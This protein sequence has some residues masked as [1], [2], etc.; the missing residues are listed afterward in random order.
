MADTTPSAS[1]PSAQNSVVART[2]IISSLVLTGLS[3]ALLFLQDNFAGFFGKYAD[4]AVTGLL[5]LAL[6]LVVSSTVRSINNLAKGAPSWKLLA[7]GVLTAFFSSLFT[8]AFLFLFPNVAKS[9]NTQEVTGASGA[10]ILVM[11]ALAFVISLISLINLRVKNRSL[12][13]LLEF[14]VIGGSILLLVYFANR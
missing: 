1:N 14:L 10:L 7:G 4:E 9:Q 12:G 6:W 11:S 3:I 8:V 13:N 2:I 5:L